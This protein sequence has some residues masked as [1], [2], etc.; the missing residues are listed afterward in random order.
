MQPQPTDTWWFTLFSLQQSV[1]IVD[2]LR[3]LSLIVI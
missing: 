3:G 1:G 2:T